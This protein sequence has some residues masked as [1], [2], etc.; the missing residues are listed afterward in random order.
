MLQGQQQVQE[1]QSNI[2][3]IRDTPP[4]QPQPQIQPQIQI[5]QQPQAKELAPSPTDFDYTR[6]TPKVCNYVWFL[7]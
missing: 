3:L 1:V 4:K 6:D 2:L 7:Y 5:P